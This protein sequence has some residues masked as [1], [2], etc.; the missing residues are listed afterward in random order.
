[1]EERREKE[2]SMWANMRVYQEKYWDDL[3][4]TSYP[5][6]ADEAG[7][8]PHKTT[9]ANKFNKTKLYNPIQ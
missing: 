2:A 5:A 7:F 8:S 4:T 1:M 6:E 3:E 9:T